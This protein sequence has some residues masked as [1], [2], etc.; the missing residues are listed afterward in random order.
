MKKSYVVGVVGASGLVG[1]EVVQFLARGNFPVKELR[2]FAGMED[3]GERIEFQG[4]EIL[5]QPISA[6]YYKDLD[7]VFF[8]THPLVSRDL[9]EEAAKAKAL[10]IDAGRAFRLDQRV[11][12][13]V[14]ELNPQALK[15]VKDG[16]RIIAS[17][18]PAA[19][20]LALALKPLADKFGLKRAIATALYGSTTGG[21]L[22]FEEHQAQ[23]VAIFNSQDFEAAKFPRQAAFNVF[24]QVGPFVADATREELDI[25]QELR[26][27]LS[28]PGLSVSVTCAQVPVFAGLSI[29]CCAELEQ[30]AEVE[31]VRKIFRSQPGLMVMDEP[32]KEVYPDVLSCLETDHALIGRIRKA[33]GL[34]AG[35]HFWIALDNLRKGS[36]LNMTG[37][38]QSVIEQGLL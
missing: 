2:L 24:P 13:V 28:A 36:A 33:P 14:A 6:D 25:E 37:I 27:I 29:S 34:N 7:L 9:A 31:A 4:D 10:V 26:K 35:F 30:P 38:A 23:T 18:G 16:A 19:I 1:G 32:A 22:G 12:L 15:A 8:A 17:P 3:A 21:R 5:V 11:P 20:G